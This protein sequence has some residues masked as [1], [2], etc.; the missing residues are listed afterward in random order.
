M[1]LKQDNEFR[2]IAS[3]YV[4]Q[5]VGSNDKKIAQG[6]SPEGKSVSNFR[7]NV[8]METSGQINFHSAFQLGSFVY[9][10]Q[11]CPDLP[12]AA[13]YIHY[14]LYVFGIKSEI[15]IRLARIFTDEFCVPLDPADFPE[16]HM[17]ITY[18]IPKCSLTSDYAALPTEG[19]HLL[20]DEKFSHQ[21]LR[22]HRVESFNF[23]R[24][25]EIFAYVRFSGTNFLSYALNDWQH[26]K[27]LSPLAV[28][29][30]GWKI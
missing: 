22:P 9:R 21:C 25:I 20:R 17:G 18:R 30:K 7:V 8:I 29:A 13:D 2:P 14:L 16:K 4:F 11:L 28:R 26:Q 19:L 1:N 5:D 27:Q 6:H 10:T 3:D 24:G 12:A 23:Q 15:A